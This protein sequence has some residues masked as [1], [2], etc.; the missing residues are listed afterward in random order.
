[1]TIAKTV[2]EQIGGNRF[3]AMTGAKNFVAPTDGLMFSLP[4]RFAKN[5]INR[6][7]ITLHVD[8]TYSVGFYKFN[9]NRLTIVSEFDGLFAEDLA[10]TFEDVTGLCT[11]L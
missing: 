4:S 3:I 8:D 10:P 5:G 7:R 9:R 6:V 11:R 1:M 2:L